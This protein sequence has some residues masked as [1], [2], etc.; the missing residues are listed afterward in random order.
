MLRIHTLL[1]ITRSGLEHNS[2]LSIG[3]NIDVSVQILVLLELFTGL[4]ERLVLEQPVQDIELSE[5]LFFS[6]VS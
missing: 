5:V 1:F 2:G 4:N 3:K 6:K